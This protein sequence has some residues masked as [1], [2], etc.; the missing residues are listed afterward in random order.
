MNKLIITQSS[1]CIKVWRLILNDI[2]S[3]NLLYEDQYDDLRKCKICNNGYI[4]GTDN[5]ELI[6][7]DLN[8]TERVTVDD[9]ENNCYQHDN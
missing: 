1:N 6:L 4:A 9:S 2:F 5:N 7:C 8:E 3:I